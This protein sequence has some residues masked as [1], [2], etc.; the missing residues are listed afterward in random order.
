MEKSRI[1]VTG[2]N[3]FVGIHTVEALL[4]EGYRVLGIDLSGDRLEKFDSHPNFTLKKFD[5]LDPRLF[6]LI[7]PGDKVLH[8][9]AISTFDAAGAN[10]RYALRMN[11]EGTI[12]VVDACIAKK[13]ERLVYGST[14]NVYRQNARVPI[15]ERE[16]LGPSVD[17][18]YGWTKLQAEQW[19]RNSG[20][21]LPYII[22]RYGYIYG[23]HKEGGAIGKFLQRIKKGEPPEIYGGSQKC[24]FIYVK[25]VAR[26]NILALEAQKLN[27]IYNIGTGRA[28]SIRKVCNLCLKALN[29]NL[30]PVV[31]PP[32]SFDAQ[33]FVYDVRRAEK[34][35]GFRAR[36]SLWEGLMDM[37]EDEKKNQP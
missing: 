16:K 11:V 24:D 3:G 5:I 30:K 22:L 8:L 2:A 37:L 35:L 1:V 28:L 31:K 34:D 9:A 29:S 14:G 13:A 27:K 25:D 17:S 10:R 12:N 18:D 23:R 20:K 32:R 6:K 4:A 21:K 26:A 19:V 7:R 33:N 15:S 36:Y